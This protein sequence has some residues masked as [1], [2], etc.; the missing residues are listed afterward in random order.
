MLRGNF[1]LPLQMGFGM[2]LGKGPLGLIHLQGEETELGC[3]LFFS[4][5]IFLQVE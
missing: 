4:G 3:S 2:A 1:K 5:G